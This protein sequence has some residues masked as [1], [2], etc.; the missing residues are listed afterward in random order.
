M[1]SDPR[2]GVELDSDPR[3]GVELDPDRRVGVESDAEAKMQVATTAGMMVH[4][5][6][7]SMLLPISHNL[8]TPDQS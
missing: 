2:V 6:Y 3:V 5:L 1:D 4:F 7:Q 8:G